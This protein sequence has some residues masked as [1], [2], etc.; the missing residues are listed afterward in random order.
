MTSV[1]VFN[2]SSVKQGQMVN[3]NTTAGKTKAG[4]AQSTGVFASLMNSGNYSTGSQ[5]LAADVKGST[6]TEATAKDFDRQTYRER[7]IAMADTKTVTD[8]ISEST[9]TLDDFEENVVQAVAEEL[10]VSEESVKEALEILGLTVF[11]LMNPQNLVQLAIGLTEENSPAELLT[12]PQFL[13]LMQD[14]GEISTQLMADLCLAPEQMDELVAQMDILSNPQPVTEE[15]L[16]D[17]PEVDAAAVAVP[18]ENAQL[19][20]QQEVTVTSE[21]IPETQVVVQTTEEAETPDSQNQQNQQMEE[22]P[23]KQEILQKQETDGRQPLQRQQNATVEGHAAPVMQAAGE[24]SIQA[25]QVLPLPEETYLSIDTM[26]LIEQIAENVR[27]NVSQAETSLEMQLNPEN[28]GKIYLQ[29]SAK[30]GAVSAQIAASNEAV[31]VA[32]EAQVADLRE[33]LNQSG[34]RVDAIEV[35]VASHEFEQ[36]L[37]QNF[38]REEQQGERQEEQSMRRRNINLSSLDELSSVMSEE[39]ALVAQMMRDNGNS[40]DLTA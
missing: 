7:E 29:I 9:D 31:K 18:A 2:L 32:L 36:S 5:N 30:E 4:S 35:T 22:A 40:V 20:T 21:E 12:N 25:D 8:R 1:N 37:E 26:D 6:G 34:V 28:L 13:E 17:T 19:Q 27:V 24:M 23:Q 15:I 10:D 11:D 38:H 33:S 14:V 39:E 3:A 16:T